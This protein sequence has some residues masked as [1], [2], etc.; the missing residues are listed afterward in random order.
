MTP[1]TC[2]QPPADTHEHCPL[3][4][5]VEYVCC[6]PANTEP[7]EPA[8]EGPKRYVAGHGW[9]P[10]AQAE[11][12]SLPAGVAPS[13]WLHVRAVEGVASQCLDNRFEQLTQEQFRALRKAASLNR[14]RA[15]KRD[16]IAALVELHP[17]LGDVASRFRRDGE[18]SERQIGAAERAIRQHAERE[19]KRL[20]REA[21]WAAERAA[22]SPAPAGRVQ[23]TGKVIKLVDYPSDYAFDGYVTKMI[24]VDDA[25]WRVFIT[26]PAAIGQVEQG[27][28]VKFM[29]KLEPKSDDPTFAKGSRPTKAEILA[30]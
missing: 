28:R 30:D 16:R 27:Q 10:A 1:T 2:T 21:Q 22:A 11:L 5:C 24:V 17:L 12:A 23:V 26:V 4:G 3:H 20:A 6:V 25:G 18:L 29:A 8:A 19:A 13:A 14:E 15:A 7:S 9:L